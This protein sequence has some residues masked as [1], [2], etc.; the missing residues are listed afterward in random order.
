MVDFPNKADSI[1]PGTTPD[2]KYNC[3]AA[4]AKTKAEKKAEAQAKAKAEADAKLRQALMQKKVPEETC[5]QLIDSG[6]DPKQ[7]REAFTCDSAPKPFNLKEILKK[8]V[9]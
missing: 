6:L 1:M 2:I 4:P 3:E 7:V 8:S 9:K 5:Q